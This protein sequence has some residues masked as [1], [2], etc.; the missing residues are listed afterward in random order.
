MVD[1]YGNY[2]RKYRMVYDTDNLI[3]AV[4]FDTF[5][6]AKDNLFATYKLWMQIEHAKWKSAEPTEEDEDDWDYMIYNCICWIEE[7]QEDGEYA[8]CYEPT[9][10]ELKEIGWDFIGAD[11][12]VEN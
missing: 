7:L 8:F 4:T 12:G 2:K 9:D 11:F 1:E 6:E 10:D 5:D 3:D